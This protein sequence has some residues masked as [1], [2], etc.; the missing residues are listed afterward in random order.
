[1]TGGLGLALV[2]HILDRHDGR[3]TIESVPGQGR[4]SRPIC[5]WPA[6]VSAKLRR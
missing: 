6:T 4:R 5:R 3:L 1:M 2:K